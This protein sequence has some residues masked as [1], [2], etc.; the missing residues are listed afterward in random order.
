[1]TPPLTCK[2]CGRPIG[3]AEVGFWARLRE[4]CGLD[5]R[6]DARG[7]INCTEC[8]IEIICTPLEGEDEVAP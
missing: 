2:R 8:V 7:P 6:P 1:V 3:D 5:L 4:K